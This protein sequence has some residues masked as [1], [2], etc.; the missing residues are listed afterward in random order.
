MNLLVS[1]YSGNGLAAPADSTEVTKRPSLGDV[2]VFRGPALVANSL[3]RV[4]ERLMS[5]AAEV[6]MGNSDQK[7]FCVFDMRLPV[8]ARALV[9]EIWH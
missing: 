1:R 2:A 3:C 7:S 8:W 6:Q 5:V 9:K 4:Q